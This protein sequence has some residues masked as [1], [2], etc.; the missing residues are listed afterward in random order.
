MNKE[1]LNIPN[2]K[3]IEIYESMLKIRLTEEKLIELNPEQL[4]KSP[5]H[6]YNGQEAVAVGVGSSPLPAAAKTER[7]PSVAAINTSSPSST[8][9][10]VVV[11]EKI[12]S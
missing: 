8:P 1:K 3:L 10:T 11:P 4:M 9:E 5:H 12:M 7:V 6:Y 2:E